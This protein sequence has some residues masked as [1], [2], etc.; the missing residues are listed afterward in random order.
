MEG[1]TMSS[2]RPPR[3]TA[4]IALDD[5]LDAHALWLMQRTV[6]ECPAPDRVRIVDLGRSGSNA[7]QPR[8]R[9]EISDLAERPAV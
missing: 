1:P 8:Y 4:Q 9:L 3:T 7:G 5:R 6:R 2:T